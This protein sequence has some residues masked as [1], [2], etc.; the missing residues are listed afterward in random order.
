LCSLDV[1]ALRSLAPAGYK[2]APDGESGNAS[3]QV[4]YSLVRT[5]GT[6]PL[7]VVES[8]QRDNDE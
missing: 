8:A 5:S 6:V 3:R 7:R 2:T 1:G 4:S